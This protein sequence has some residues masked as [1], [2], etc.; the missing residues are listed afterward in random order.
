MYHEFIWS[1]DVQKVAI[2]L[3][4]IVLSQF[5]RDRDY[6]KL[7]GQGLGWFSRSGVRLRTYREPAGDLTICSNSLVFTN[8]VVKTSHNTYENYSNLMLQSFPM[9]L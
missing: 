6:E 5:E 9:F 4:D 7:Q 8:F 1:S 3:F 2:D